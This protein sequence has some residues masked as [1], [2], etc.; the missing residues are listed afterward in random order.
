LPPSALLMSAS[1]SATSVFRS[2]Y[3][4]IKES[5]VCSFQVYQEQT[6]ISM[7]LPVEP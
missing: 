2:S 6:K 5:P 1:V 7:N 4:C 3:S